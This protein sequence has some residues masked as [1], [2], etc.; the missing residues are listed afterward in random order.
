MQEGVD[1]WHRENVSWFL[2]V[3]LVGLGNVLCTR[4][5]VG[6]AEEDIGLSHWWHGSRWPVPLD[7][8]LDNTRY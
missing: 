7:A 2:G 8:V 5:K 4:H 6:Q 3:R 1:T